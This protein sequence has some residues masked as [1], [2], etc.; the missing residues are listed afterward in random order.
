MLLALPEPWE[1]ISIAVRCF[2]N[3]LFPEPVA[4][5]KSAVAKHF[6]ADNGNMNAVCCFMKS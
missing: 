6:S 5:F 4:Q 1:N 3:A 2:C